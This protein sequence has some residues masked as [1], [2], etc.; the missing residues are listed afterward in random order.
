MTC[1]SI[2]KLDVHSPQNKCPVSKGFQGLPIE[3][4]RTLP[5]LFVGRVHLSFKW[6]QVYF[7]A[8]ILFLIK[9]DPVSKQS[10]F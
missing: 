4:W 8:F 3:Y 6:C 9:K 2:F 7:V 1:L 10:R 5:L